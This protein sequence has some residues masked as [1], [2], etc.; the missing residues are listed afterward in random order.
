M[1]YDPDLGPDD[2]DDLSPSEMHDVWEGATNL[3]ADDLRE[4][5]DTPEHD[6]YLDEASDKRQSDDDP[7]I[8][9]GPLDDAL[10]LATTPASEW[11]SDEAEEAEEA[12]NWGARHRPQFDPDEG[13][14]LT[15][16]DG[17]KI[18]K[19]DV[20]AAR[21]GFDWRDEDGWP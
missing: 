13:E 17:E 15:P 2:L 6:R 20:S 4:L 14:D 19:A 11:G 10:H 3:Q 7:P 21:W 5:R 12:L 16:G 8:P 9:G 1:V 18:T